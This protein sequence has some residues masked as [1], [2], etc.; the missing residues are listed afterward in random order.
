MKAYCTQRALTRI[1]KAGSARLNRTQRS[2]GASTACVI[3]RTPNLPTKII[4][5]KIASLKLSGR[6]PMDMRIPPL[7]IKLLLE[8]NL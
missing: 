6:F 5:T 8:S 3:L 7:R 4:P 2:R 1:D